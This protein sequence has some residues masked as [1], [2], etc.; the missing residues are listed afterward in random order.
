MTRSSSEASWAG[1]AT[2]PSKGA[3]GQTTFTAKRARMSFSAGPATTRSTAFGD[4][5]TK[6]RLTCG[7]GTD[8]AFADTKDKVSNDCENV[9]PER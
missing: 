7:S 8:T 5:N 6:D 3:T 1:P 4:N 9:V 2:T